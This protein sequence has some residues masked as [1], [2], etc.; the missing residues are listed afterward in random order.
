LK[1]E[2]TMMGWYGGGM[3]SL[4]GLA[5]GLFWLSLLALIVWLVIRLLPDSNDQPTRSTD[6]SALDL[7]DRRL[8][9]GEIDMKDWQT[10]RVVLLAARGETR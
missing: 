8:A 9:S 7:L 6:E 10:Q 2:F 1:E 3:G 5:M 4:G